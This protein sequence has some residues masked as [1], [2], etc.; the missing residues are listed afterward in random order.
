M[1]LLD[2]ASPARHDDRISSTLGAGQVID[3]KG[4]SRDG[5]YLVL[6]R[7]AR[8]DG[9]ARYLV[10]ATSGRVS[11]LGYRD[12]VGGSTIAGEMEVPL[13]VR[14]KDRRYVQD[15]L[16]S[17]RR[18]PPRESSK[19][20]RRHPVIDHPVAGCPDAARH[21][22]AVR[23]AKRTRR[24]LEQ[25][26]EA[27][28][29]SGHGLVEEFG[30]IRRLL[31]DL[32]YLSGWELTGRGQRLRGIYNESDLLLAETL[33]RG[34]FHDLEPAELAALTSV[35]VYEPRSDTTSL[36]EWPT[37]ALAE[38]WDELER[39]WKD[40]VDRERS[41]RLA[42]TRRPDPGFGVPA[43][44]WASGVDFDDLSTRGMAPGDFVR[45]S[46]QLVDLV[47]QLRDTAPG[48]RQEAMAVLRAIDRGVVAAQG[49]G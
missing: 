6:K 13:P 23:R 45:V 22:A 25:Y 18:V 3:I 40:L 32:D 20:L 9:G 30:A 5:R 44:E 1:A 26:R 10:L 37:A 46:R 28:R 42:P 17:L 19:E 49:V 47:R 27:R 8:K 7:L 15:L 21:L 31:E 14:P 41:L 29:G 34:L 43:F 16:R 36:A 33:E 48:L 2:T 24:K 39:I 38:R 11:T 35:F 4:G 12:V